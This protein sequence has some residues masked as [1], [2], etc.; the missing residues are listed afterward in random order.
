MVDLVNIGFLECKNGDFQL[1]VVQWE[2]IEASYG[3][4]GDRGLS[5]GYACYIVSIHDI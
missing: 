3:L 4:L 2:V 5:A 1:S